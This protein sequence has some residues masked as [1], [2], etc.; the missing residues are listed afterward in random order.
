MNTRA[1]ETQ[2]VEW[3]VSILVWKCRFQSTMAPKSRKRSKQRFLAT[4]TRFGFLGSLF[5]IRE[6]LRFRH[7]PI[8]S[9]ALKT[10]HSIYTAHIHRRYKTRMIFPEHEQNLLSLLLFLEQPFSC[11]IFCYSL[12][13][14]N[15][16]NIFH[17]FHRQD[18]TEQK[19]HLFSFRVIC[20][21]TYVI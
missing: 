3:K 5:F 14:T 21:Y 7:L 12:Q 19:S 16:R 9:T 1:A 6:S 10:L 2:S 20:L 13:C 15:S 4:L 17:H 8:P 18:A 11:V